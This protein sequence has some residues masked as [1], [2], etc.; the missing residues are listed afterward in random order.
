MGDADIVELMERTASKVVKRDWQVYHFYRKDEETLFLEK[1]KEQD[2]EISQ[3]SNILEEDFRQGRISR[4]HTSEL[5]NRCSDP[6]GTQPWHIPK[7]L[8]ATHYFVVESLYVYLGCFSRLL[9]HP[10]SFLKAFEV[11]DHRIELFA[12]GL[13]DFCGE[14]Y[15]LFKY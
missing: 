9:Q 11:A 2:R 3:G 7:R 1:V 10:N 12:E 8:L 6:F 5:R 13:H 15:Q 4:A 14:L